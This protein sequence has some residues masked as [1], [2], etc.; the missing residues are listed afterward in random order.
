[1]A[2]SVFTEEWRRCLKEHYKTVV[3][4]GDKLTERTLV[5]VLHRVGFTDDELRQLYVEATM[6][7]D[8]MPDDFVPEMPPA[9]EMTEP[10]KVVAPH[11]AECTCD[12][13]RMDDII[14][15]GHDADGQPVAVDPE[16]EDDGETGHIFPVAK[17]GEGE[18]DED[19]ADNPQ[20]MSM[21]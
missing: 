6:R 16:L 19:D 20:Q 8:D 12:V 10:E 5:P 2:Q 1:M 14:E 9:P 18:S 11:P 3:R 4:N 7:A 15:Q 13:C 17:T 21:F